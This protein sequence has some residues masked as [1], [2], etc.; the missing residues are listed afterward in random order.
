[1]IAT[2]EDAVVC[3]FAETY[4]IYDFRSLPLRYAATLAY[5]FRE[6][7]RIKILLSGQRVS[8]GTMLEAAAVDALNLLVWMKTKDGAKNRNRPASIVETLTATQTESEVVGFDNSAAFD[9]AYNELIRRASN[10]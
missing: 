4:H 8:T 5:G 9:R 1:M 2:D 3:D 10:A 7:S 6:D